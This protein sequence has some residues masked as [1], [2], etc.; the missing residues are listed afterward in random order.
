[1]SGAR[2]CAGHLTFEK[3]P[4]ARAAYGEGEI[5]M[6]RTSFALLIV[7]F[8]ATAGVAHAQDA[9]CEPARLKEKY[10]SL[11]GKTVKV[12]LDGLQRPFTYRDPQNP[13][14]IIGVDIDLA[15][16]TFD[17]IGVPWTQS[18]GV[19][20]GL[21]TSVTEGRNDVMWDT[22]NYTPARAQQVN[23]ALY[24]SAA[25][26]FI[27]HAGNPKHVNSLDSICGLNAAAGLGTVE[28]AAFHD[29]GKKCVSMGKPDINLVTYTDLNAGLRQVASGRVD[30][31]MTDLA[32]SNI[33]VADQPQN[34]A[35]AFNILSG[36]HVGV[37]VNK[38]ET[39][40]LQAIAEALKVVQASGQQQAILAKYK[41]D[42]SLQYPVE[43]KT[44]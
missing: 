37:A 27:V 2:G 9:K 1:L 3:G 11:V 34:L 6:I 14:K 18:V 30:V 4:V 16:A 31:I 33:L 7:L 8:L 13:D 40:L 39:E 25:T 20:A 35:L 36:F 29:L 10:P 23:Y 24:L 38:G 21:I 19:W 5:A 15:K 12:A 32:M 22:L 26:G 28:E 41:V 17:C 43:I 42:P 44:E